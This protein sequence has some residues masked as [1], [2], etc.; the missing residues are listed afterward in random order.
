MALRL[1]LVGAG[2]AHLH[3]LGRARILRDAG[4]DLHL[5]SPATFLYSGL[6]TGALSGAL[7][8]D[9]GQIDI[10][11]LADAHGVRHDL[12]R[13]GGVDLIRSQARLAGGG[14]VDFDMISFNV[15]S[16]VDDPSGLRAGPGV[17]P[18]KPLA[19][20]L[21]LRGVVEAAITTSG[22]CPA[23]VIAGAGQTAFEVAAALCGLCERHGV[24]PHIT[25]VGPKVD[26]A[27]A[28]QG[29]ARRLLGALRA[30][31]IEFRADSVVARGFDACELA[32]GLS[33]ACEAL[34]LATGLVAA[35]LMRTLDLPTDEDGRLRVSPRLQALGNERVFAVGDCGVLDQDPRPCVGVFGVRAA[36]ILVQ[37][38]VAFA[39]SERL[40]AYR[41]QRRWLS[42]MDLGDGTGLVLRGQIWWLGRT[43][44]RLKRWLDLGFVRRAHRGTAPIKKG[45]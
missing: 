27:W 18:V 6:A 43:A 37:N 14:T 4:I 35:D 40:A 33:L 8:L 29:A 15:G 25:V 21:T 1:V 22:R 26:A 42:I 44:L 16:I 41:P 23:I 20:L 5:I 30:R 19:S 24:G 45:V 3:V 2:H 12:D 34:V 32:S 36:P 39:R 13:V 17:W 11:A 31:G 28:P 38:L 7:D 9:A 10:A